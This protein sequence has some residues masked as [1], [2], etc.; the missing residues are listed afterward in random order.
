MSNQSFTATIKGIPSLPFVRVRQGPGTSNAE[1][2]QVNVGETGLVVLE[3][4]PD[5]DGKNFNGKVYQWLRLVFSDNSAGWVRDDLIEVEGDGTPLGYGMVSTRTLAFDLTRQAVIAPG[6]ETISPKVS[7]QPAA[8]AAKTTEKADKPAATVPTPESKSDEK[9]EKPG[10]G[11]RLKSAAKTGANARPGPGSGHQPVLFKFPYLEEAEIVD[12]RSG[13]GD[14]FTW[15]KIRYQGQEG[16]VR[17][18]YMRLVSG[19][20]TFKLGYEDG[21]SSPVVNTWWVRDFNLDP[22]FTVVHLGWDHGAE[23]G[24]P[25]LAGPAGGFVQ[26]AV[27]C[28]KCGPSGA[29]SYPTFKLSDPS[30]LQDPGWNFGYGNYVIVRY[31]NEQLPASTRAQ[32]KDHGLGGAH[33]YAMHAHLSAILVQ[34]GMKVEAGQPIG[35]VGTSGNSEAPHLHLEVR[36]SKNPNDSNWASMRP[37]LVT[38]GILFRR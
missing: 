23:I 13:E 21:Y 30:V 27:P 19:Y 6:Q 37:N 33:L 14:P 12:T 36:A 31:L 16:W 35:K 29:S 2:R 9:M 22:N 7:D 10:Q 11:A 32:L 15:I 26:R 28:K 17:E 24:E 5:A 8:E 20:Q 25:V 4:M 38:P 18:D 1:I 34:Q 3:A